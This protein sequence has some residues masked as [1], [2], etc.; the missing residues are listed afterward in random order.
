MKKQKR[1]WTKWIWRHNYDGG[2][3]IRVGWIYNKNEGVKLDKI[4][5]QINS[6]HSKL[7]FD[8][9]LD[10]AASLIA[11]LGKVICL[12]TLCNNIILKGINP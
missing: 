9:R 1:Q 3:F 4:R 5:V 7:E 6:L 10:E 8:M 2:T 12:E 11:G